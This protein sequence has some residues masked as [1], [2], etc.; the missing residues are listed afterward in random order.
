M[1]AVL[2][3]EPDGIRR[4]AYPDI[5]SKI[6]ECSH[7]IGVAASEPAS[8]L[9]GRR[10]PRTGANQP[11]GFDH[12]ALTGLVT[13][14]FGLSCPTGKPDWLIVFWSVFFTKSFI[15]SV[16]TPSGMGLEM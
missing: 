15:Q 3:K 14:M 1:G 5:L 6:G 16:M 13:S 8:I 12:A 11:V 2:L 9:L 4:Y 7:K 10:L